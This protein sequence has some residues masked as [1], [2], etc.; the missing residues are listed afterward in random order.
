MRRR[1][2]AGR[3][4]AGTPRIVIVGGTGQALSTAVLTLGE[5]GYDLTVI[6][7]RALATLQKKTLFA[8]D[9]AR[10]VAMDIF[11]PES[12]PA[13]REIASAAD[14]VVMGAEPHAIERAR[15]DDA[16]CG[17]KRVYAALLDAGYAT[18]DN[19]AR[20]QSGVWPRR[21][22]RIGSPPAEIPR[23]PRSRRADF[24][25]DSVTSDALLK[26]AADADNW[27]NVYFQA[28]VRC[29]MV[30]RQA[31]S[32]G[33]DLVTASPT[34]VISWAGDWGDREPILQFCQSDLD[35]RPRFL[36]ST[37]T[38]VVPGDV[39]ARGIMLAALAGTTGGVYQLAGL[40]LQ[41][42][43]P[44]RYLLTAMGE[45]V[46]PVRIYSKP[47][48][49]RQVRLLRGESFRRSAS[50]MA[51]YSSRA[52]SNVGLML[53]N[54]GSFGLLT[55]LAVMKI[56]ADTLSG[57]IDAIR[58]VY[59]NAETVTMRALGIED[60]QVALL[61]EMRSRRAD[62]VRS[63]N[64][65]VRGTR[66]ADLAY[67]T[68]ATI[69]RQLPG[70]LARHAAWLERRGLIRRP[71]GVRPRGQTSGSDL[72]VRP[73]GQTSGSNLG[74]KPRTDTSGAS[75]RSTHILQHSHVEFI[76]NSAYAHQDSGVINRC[77]GGPVREWPGLWLEDPVC[78]LR[79]LSAT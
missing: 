53:A 76:E 61:A 25:E 50:D 19:A 38:N 56:A 60:W 32:A 44:L 45:T 21:V 62:K 11:A 14:I 55:P 49:D 71:V 48:L 77:S 27:Q 12:Q 72:G 78:R 20:R 26:R 1:I 37:L 65:A 59:E 4:P 6:G 7:R 34:G 29:A 23:A 67:P 22:V 31:V 17:V 52:W 66:F 18:D 69:S 64:N 63:L 16:V 47:S 39:V 58:N 13:L 15:L 70:A 43:E 57:S 24:L 10:Y 46:P 33:L 40:D 28:K 36:P 42:A 35:L 75:R 30:A 54:A 5:L 68:A 41:S 51:E 79:I 73:G 9:R 8:R 2:R 3:F 74:V